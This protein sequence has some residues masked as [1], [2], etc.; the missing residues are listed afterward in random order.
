MTRYLVTLHLLPDENTMEY[1]KQLHGIRELKL[2]ED[3]GLVLISPKRNLYTIR[4]SGDI[5]PDNL[6]SIQPKVKGVYADVKI[7]PIKS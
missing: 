3:Y 2:D 1:V 5:D 7:A 4:V 6:M